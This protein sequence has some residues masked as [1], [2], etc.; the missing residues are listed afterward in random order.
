MASKSTAEYDIGSKREIYRSIGIGEYWLFDASGGSYY[1][2]PLAGERLANGRYQRIELTEEADGSIR[3]Y[4]PLLDLYIS[5]EPQ[6]QGD[7]RFSLYY[8]ATGQRMENYREVV[9]SRRIAEERA[10]AA[11]QE[12]RQLRERLNRLKEQ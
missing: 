3:G 7:A 9:A 10:A 5:W 11:E 4:S 6:E 8:P 12:V 2:E 1:G